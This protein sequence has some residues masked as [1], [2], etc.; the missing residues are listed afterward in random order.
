MPLAQAAATGEAAIAATQ[1]RYDIVIVGGGPAGCACALALVQQGQRDILLLEADDYT[2]FRI[3]ESIPPESRRLFRSLGI[4]AAFMA[5]AH[6]P[7]YGSCSYWGSEQ[8]GYNDTLLSPHGHGWHLDRT[9]FNRFLAQRVRAA[10]VEVRTGT[11]L[12]ASAPAAVGYTLD[13]DAGGQRSRIDAGFVVDASGMRH[14][15]ARQRGQRKLQ[16]D[17]LLC[18]AMRYDLGQRSMS[19]LTHLEAA[20][21]GWWYAARLPGGQLL[22][23]LYSDAETVKAM[24]LQHAPNW[25]AQ[26]ACAGHTLRLTDGAACLDRQVR[27]FPAASDHLDH[28]SG[29]NW[30]AIGDAASAYDPITAQGIVKSLAN[31]LQAA[32]AITQQASGDSASLARY[33]Q[34]IGSDYDRYREARR[35]FYGLE[36]R[37]PA[38]GFWRRRQQR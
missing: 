17:A 29:E 6:D 5:E 15:F 25:R 7:C 4:D 13:L 27:S 22:V 23:S 3:G 2:G 36:R 32:A 37:W 14:L 16:H 12:L 26:L 11:A 24:R 33:A 8:R 1:A 35:Y 9:R 20:E 18:L 10:G 28:A 38:S 31:G 21:H 34:G 30:L 19:S